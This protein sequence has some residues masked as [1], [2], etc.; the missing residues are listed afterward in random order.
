MGPSQT[1]AMLAETE[2]SARVNILLL[3]AYS[4]AHVGNAAL[5]DSSLL[6]LREAFPHARFTVHAKSPASYAACEGIAMSRGLFP[7]LFSPSERRGLCRFSWAA[8]NGAWMAAT[9]LHPGLAQRLWP[10]EERRHALDQ[11]REATL[12]ISISGEMLNEVFARL[13]PFMLHTYRTVQRLGKPLVFFPQSIGP[14]ER[15]SLRRRVQR[16]LAQ[17]ALV[18]PRDPLSLAETEAM[19]LPPGLVHMVPD[20]AVLQPM[21]DPATAERLLRE[22]GV[23]LNRRPLAGFTLSRFLDDAVDKGDRPYLDAVADLARYVVASLG[24]SAVFLSAN[25]GAFGEEQS[26]VPAAQAVLAKLPKDIRPHAALIERLYAPREFKAVTRCFDAY[27]TT[28]MHAGILATMAGTPTIALS[29][30]R[31]LRGYMQLIGLEAFAVEP[32]GAADERLRE[33][34]RR[35]LG[36]RAELQAQLVRK[37]SELA[38]KVHALPDLLRQRVPGLLANP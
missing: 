13:M 16:M 33:L 31:K 2:D 10:A 5:L 17:S 6:L 25:H 36:Q 32:Y 18:C 12:V 26:D 3:D 4:A 35:C 29:T 7:G 34:L 28:R 22:A 20:V 15:P 1:A 19:R 24:G 38:A 8:A 21:A 30:Q 14:L 9:G 23:D 37:R 11:I 27:L